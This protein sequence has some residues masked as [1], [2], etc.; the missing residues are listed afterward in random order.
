MTQSE[1]NERIV[2]A[3]VLECG[4]YLL[5]TLLTAN[6]DD[7][8]VAWFQDSDFQQGLNVRPTS[9]NI[10]KVRQF[11]RNFDGQA[12]HIVGIWDVEHSILIGFYIIEINRRHKTAQWTVAIGN[13]AYWGK[14]ILLETG[15]NLLR[16]MFDKLDVD[17]V[18]AR[19]LAKNKRV[20]FNFLQQSDF[21]LQAVLPQEV[22]GPDGKRLDVL[23]FA[24]LRKPNRMDTGN[25]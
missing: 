1:A 21:L 6:V 8:F 11:I 20:F 5:R 16:Y 17:K 12:K 18:T 15:Q 25:D 3:I 2:P 19:V 9:W 22:L 7:R 10:E 24:A 14:N 23:S 13:K 4:G